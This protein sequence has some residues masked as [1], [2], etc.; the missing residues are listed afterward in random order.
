MHALGWLQQRRQTYICISELYCALPILLST[1]DANEHAFFLRRREVSQKCRPSLL[2]CIWWRDLFS[3]LCPRCICCWRRVMRRKDKILY[4]LFFLEYCISCWSQVLR[5]VAIFVISSTSNSTP[6]PPVRCLGC[7]RRRL[8]LSST[9]AVTI[10]QLQQIRSCLV[11][12]FKISNLSY[13]NRNFT[14]MEY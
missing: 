2:L 4:K 13:G 12:K 3:S 1:D 8:L 11:A 5:M 14:C 9:S 6:R 10:Q 7:C